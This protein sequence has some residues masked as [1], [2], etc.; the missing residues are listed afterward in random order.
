MQK[1]REYFGKYRDRDE[2][3]YLSKDEVSFMIAPPNYDPSNAEAKHLIQEADTNKVSSK[4]YT[5]FLMNK[6]EIFSLPKISL[7]Y[8][9]FECFI[10]SPPLQDKLLSKEEILNHQ[11]LF[12]GS[13]A[14]NYGNM[15]HDEF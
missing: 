1:E 9:M 11:D 4:V 15:K 7:L 10:L 3:G 14:T 6:N 5:L 12:V 13:R 8:Q 2:D